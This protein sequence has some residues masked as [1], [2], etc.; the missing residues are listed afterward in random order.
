MGRIG[1]AALMM[2]PWLILVLSAATQEPSA[3]WAFQVPRRP[4]VPAV[5]GARHPI[6]AFLSVAQQAR[7]LAPLGP[8]DKNVLLRRVTLDLT[9]LP[10]TRQALAAF[11]A[12]D[13]PGA[14]EKL[15]DRLL[16]D[17]SHGERWGRHWMDVWRYSDWYGRRSVPDVMNSYPMIWRWR[18]WIVRSINE[19]K[20][21]DRMIVEMLAADEVAPEADADRVATGFLVRSWFKWNYNTWMRDLVEHTGKAFLGLTLNCAHCHDHKYDPITQEDYFR[22]RAFFEP[23]ELRHDRVPGEPDPGPF[24]KYVYAQSY[25]PIASGRVGVFDEK[26]DAETYVYEDGDQRHRIEGRPPVAP[27]VPAALGGDPPRVE[28]VELPPTAHYPGLK[29]FIREEERTRRLAA[30]ADADAETSTPAG[31]ARLEAAVAEHASIE[32]R[33]AADAAR[34]PGPA[35]PEIIREACRLE[36]TAALATA[37]ADLAAAERDRADAE[38][39]AAADEKAAAQVK[40]AKGRIDAAQAA[41]KAAEAALAQEPTDYTPL[42]PKYPTRSTGRRAALARWIASPR[43]PLAARVAVNHVWARHFGSPLVETVFDFGRNGKPPSHPELLDWLAVE[44][45]EHG[46]SFKHL[47]RLIVTSDA[48]RRR[49]SAGTDGSPNAATDPDNRWLWRFNAWRLESE[50]VRDALICAA[51]ELDRTIGGPELDPAQ[52]ET[53]RRRSLYFAIHGEGAMELLRIFDAP[54]VCDGY[55]RASSIQPQQALALANSA[56][57]RSM[58]RAAAAALWK[59]AEE[60]QDAF[61]IAAFEQILG[62]PP[63]DEERAMAAEFLDRQAKLSNAASARESLVHVL[64]NHNDFVTVR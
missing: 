14:Y 28:P 13:S 16:A 55:R 40:A 58:S 47:H 62:R 60:S 35:D 64:F 52:G 44:F 12:D 7:G 21:Y 19:D 27:G 48:Y 59:S 63:A 42:S 61:V 9:G 46:W 6:D 54:N 39:R 22:F 49:S 8:A 24:K 32:A 11:L 38:A 56:L 43:N 17:P 33:L 34:Y 37:R 23:L 45:M 31:L 57:A 41:I 18:D 2:K 30:L 26:L 4:A 15:V 36:R 25:G 10:P 29:P 3:H 20:P 53:S 50:G 5:A 51:G 1:G